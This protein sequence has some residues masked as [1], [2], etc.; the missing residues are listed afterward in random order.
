M[1]FNSINIL[2]TID[3]TILTTTTIYFIVVL[4]TY[5]D[6]TIQTI[7]KKMIKMGATLFLC[8]GL[9]IQLGISGLIICDQQLS[10]SNSETKMDTSTQVSPLAFLGNRLN[11]AQKFIQDAHSHL[12]QNMMLPGSQELTPSLVNVLNNNNNNNNSPK[13]T[14]EDQS[15]SFVDSSQN[16]AESTLGK[17][18]NRLMMVLT[19]NNN[20]VSL[21]YLLCSLTSLISMYTYTHVHTTNQLFFFLTQQSHIKSLL[22]RVTNELRLPIA[23]NNNNYPSINNAQIKPVMNES[24]QHLIV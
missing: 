14:T 2:F 11:L 16:R 9:V 3:Q 7:K 24:Q 5:I 20:Q 21:L 22:K 4:L 15:Q 23:T 19:Q 12:H 13:T 10:A 18:T 8:L 17:L 1:I 6:I